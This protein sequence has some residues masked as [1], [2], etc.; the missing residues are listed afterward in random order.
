MDTF[1]I[2]GDY[3]AGDAI[4]FKVDGRLFTYTVTSAD[5][6]SAAG[7]YTNAQANKNIVESIAEAMTEN[8]DISEIVSTSVA[9]DMEIITNDDETYL[10]LTALEPGN[11][12]R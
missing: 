10:V 11:I 3:H 1:T 12:Y 7:S 6:S 5:V 4:D 8:I 2:S 9:R